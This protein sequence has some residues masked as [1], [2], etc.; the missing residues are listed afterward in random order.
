MVMRSLSTGDAQDPPLWKKRNLTPFLLNSQTNQLRREPLPTPPRPPHM[1]HTMSVSLYFAFLF[2]QNLGYQMIFDSPPL[3]PSSLLPCFLI[4]L[5][6]I[7][8][9]P[10][11][12]QPP[13]LS[14]C[15]GAS[16]PERSYCSS[17]LSSSQTDIDLLRVVWFRLVWFRLLGCRVPRLI[18]TCSMA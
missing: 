13:R 14:P 17:R 3:F 11:L 12:S 15:H 7:I 4:S 5:P 18:S 9:L 1:E 2:P 10:S 16:M 8:M 6:P